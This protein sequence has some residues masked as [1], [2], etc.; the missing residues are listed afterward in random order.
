MAVG[1]LKATYEKVKKIPAHPNTGQFEN[2]WEK[3]IY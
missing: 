2:I 1:A 3:V